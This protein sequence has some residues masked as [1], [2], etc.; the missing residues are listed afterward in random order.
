MAWTHV[1][2]SEMITASTSPLQLSW[3]HLRCPDREDLGEV[4][5]GGVR[6]GESN[7]VLFAYGRGVVED[8]DPYRASGQRGSSLGSPSIRV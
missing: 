8:V 4:V 5:G 2:E 3:I 1:S 6:D 7:E